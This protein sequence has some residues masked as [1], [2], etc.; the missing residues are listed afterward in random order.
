MEEAGGAEESDEP[1]AGSPG[2]GA[3]D[4]FSL[5]PRKIVV[6][7]R[8]KDSFVIDSHDRP[9]DFINFLTLYGSGHSI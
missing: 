5:P 2:D 7:S 3:D 8:S 6:C 4:P 9:W 1:M